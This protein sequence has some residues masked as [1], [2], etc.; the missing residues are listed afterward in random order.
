[1][2]IH[3]YKEYNYYVMS[4]IGTQ[5]GGFRVAKLRPSQVLVKEACQ[6]WMGPPSQSVLP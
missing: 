5:G 1:M 6:E 3:L 2:L 4:S